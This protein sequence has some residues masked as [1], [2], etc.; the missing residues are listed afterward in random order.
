[1][2]AINID[3]MKYNKHQTFYKIQQMLIFPSD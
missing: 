2:I 1:M 3:A